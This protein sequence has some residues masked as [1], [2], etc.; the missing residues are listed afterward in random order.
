LAFAPLLLAL[1]PL[2]LRNV[3]D[4][5][6]IAIAIGLNIALVFADRKRLEVVGIH[7]NRAWVL[8][9]PGYLIVRT[10]RAKTTPAIPVVWFITFFASLAVPVL[11]PA[12]AGPITMDSHKLEGELSQF[13]EQQ[14][15]MPATVTCPDNPRVHINDTFTC[16]ARDS[17]GSAHVIVQVTDADGRYQWQLTP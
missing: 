1:V 5:T 14:T 16:T 11:I 10:M 8:L 13:I 15:G 9:V 6:S 3:S 4:T 17:T 12:A 2:V 7:I